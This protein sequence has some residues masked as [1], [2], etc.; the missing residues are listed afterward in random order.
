MKWKGCIAVLNANSRIVV[1]AQG[2]QMPRIYVDEQFW[3]WCCLWLFDLL[4]LRIF[5]RTNVV[6][7]RNWLKSS[8]KW[9]SMQH[10]CWNVLLFSKAENMLEAVANISIL[11]GNNVNVSFVSAWIWYLA[12][13][14]SWNWW[15]SSSSSA[16][17]LQQQL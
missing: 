9:S 2:F 5:V 14:A 16:S 4:A 1:I 8:A 3:C 10:L 11:N 15:W 13:V 12:V 7:D 17:Q 6:N